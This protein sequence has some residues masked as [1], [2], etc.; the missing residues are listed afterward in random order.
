MK[1]FIRVRYVGATP[2]N[3]GIYGELTTGTEFSMGYK[4]AEYLKN[5]EDGWPKYLKTISESDEHE[6]KAPALS[7]G[8]DTGPTTNVDESTDSTGNDGGGTGTEDG[9]GTDDATNTE[10]DSDTRDTSGGSDCDVSETGNGGSIEDIPPYSEWEP[11]ELRDELALRGIK[12]AKKAN[13]NKLVALLEDN[14]A[15]E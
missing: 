3:L 14:D 12:H 2:L 5:T 11:R 13:K 10:D 1:A 15:S 9:S 4:D 6:D 7:K 8:A